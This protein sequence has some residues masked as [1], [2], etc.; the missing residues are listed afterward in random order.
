[1]NYN[2][3]PFIREILRQLCHPIKGISKNMTPTPITMYDWNRCLSSLYGWVNIEINEK[4]ATNLHQIKIG[5]V[6]PD[7]P[8]NMD[9]YISSFATSEIG[10][11]L[12]F[13]V[14]NF[15]TIELE[16]LLESEKKGKNYRAIMN[17]SSFS[18]LISILLNSQSNEYITKFNTSLCRKFGE[19]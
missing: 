5:Q 11:L 2:T 4:M 10:K 12:G 6:I 8:A 13:N 19:I 16:K 14:C 17:Y 1:M 9:I 3:Q 18:K 7:G 15:P